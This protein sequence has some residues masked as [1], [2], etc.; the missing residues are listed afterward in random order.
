MQ[1]NLNVNLKLYVKKYDLAIQALIL[2]K[3]KDITS[4]HYGNG[5][6]SVRFL[7]AKQ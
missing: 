2:N 4:Q 6:V 5:V 3:L 1:S 7:E